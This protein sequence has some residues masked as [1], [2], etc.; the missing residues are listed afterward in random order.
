MGQGCGAGGR[1]GQAAGASVDGRARGRGAEAAW[2]W[3]GKGEA[4]SGQ[5]AG[6]TKRGDKALSPA[7]CPAP[8]ACPEGSGG[9]MIF[10]W[11]APGLV[12][13]AS[14]GAGGSDGVLQETAACLSLL[15]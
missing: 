9:V 14:V 4:Q 12:L 7:P 5:L 2:L 1:G 11:K 13:L 6:V 8:P 15:F 3:G 10:S